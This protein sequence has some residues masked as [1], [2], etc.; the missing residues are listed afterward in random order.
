[1]FHT[2]LFLWLRGLANRQWDPTLLINKWIHTLVL[3][4]SRLQFVFDERRKYLSHWDLTF[5]PQ[6]CTIGA[7]LTKIICILYYFLLWGHVMWTC[8]S[9][10]W[11]S[12]VI[13]A[14]YE[15]IRTQQLI[16]DMESPIC[17]CSLS[18]QNR[19]PACVHVTKQPSSE[20]WHIAVDPWFIVDVCCCVVN[21][22]FARLSTIF[23]F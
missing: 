13:I 14:I 15:H 20:K 12:Q 7:S 10:R 2:H 9:Y 4:V 11:W 5:S 22:Y 16:S 19:C 6:G 8:Y 23:L 21:H 1:M 17:T 3:N 18:S